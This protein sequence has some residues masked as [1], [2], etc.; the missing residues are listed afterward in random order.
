MVLGV[1]V[2]AVAAAVAL[3]AAPPNWVPSEAQ[4][5]AMIW[6]AFAVLLAF[7]ST[8]ALALRLPDSRD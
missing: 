3:T 1:S 2:V 4:V 5:A 7:S 6:G 8:S